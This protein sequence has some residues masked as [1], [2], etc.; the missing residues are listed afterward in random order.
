MIRG[1]GIDA[2]SISDMEKRIDRM[3]DG[4]LGK[5]FTAAELKESSKRANRSAEY[6]ATRFAAKEAVYKALA[7]NAKDLSFDLRR[8]EILNHADGCPYVN[9]NGYLAPVLAAACVSEIHIS[10]TTE[11]DLAIAF[12]VAERLPLKS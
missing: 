5:M 8:I 7:H 1:I 3:S 4:A 6:L 11:S 9:V 10:I 12:V 2:V